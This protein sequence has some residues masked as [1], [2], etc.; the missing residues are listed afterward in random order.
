MKRRGQLFDKIT[1]LSNIIAA[2]NLARRGKAHYKEVKAVNVCPD[3]YCEH[4]QEW[5]INKTFTTSEYEIEIK[6][7]GRKVRE[8]YKLPYFPDRIVQHALLQV[9]IPIWQPTF[10]RDTYQSV[11]GRGTHDARKRVEKAIRGKPP[12]YA[13]KFDISKYYPSINNEKLKQIVR[14]KIKCP[15]TLWLIDDIIDS[16]KGI[17]IG[18]YTSQYFG[19]LYLTPFDWWVKQE[20]K[21]KHYFRYC[22]DIVI[23]GET[24]EYCH[25]MKDQMFPKLLHE[26]ALTVKGN[27]QVFPVEDRGLDFVGYVFKSNETRLRRSIAKGFKGKARAVKRVT[28]NQHQ[29]M[30]GL[31]SYW[32][33]IKH[34]NAKKLWMS[35]VDDRII[36][37]TDS[38]GTKRNPVKEIMK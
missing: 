12:Q 28:M 22:D 18:N 17:P 27:W 33:W 5:L 20:L 31:M 4:I 37:V 2:H 32:G 29:A 21:V 14:H 36:A 15:D 26:Y 9:C 16:S 13:L 24:A 6:H 1:D 8:I 11:I 25:A 30:S 34:A 35:R 3:Y 19:N 38:Y 23:L 10:I 7:D